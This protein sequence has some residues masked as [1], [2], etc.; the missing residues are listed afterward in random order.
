[1]NIRAHHRP[2]RQT[3]KSAERLRG[4]FAPA[5]GPVRAA[6]AA[7]AAGAHSTEES[8]LSR[9]A[10]N[11]RRPA[12]RPERRLSPPTN[13]M[14]I[15]C[16]FCAHRGRHPGPRAHRTSPVFDDIP[17]A[18]FVTPPLTTVRAPDHG[19]SAASRWMRWRRAIGRARQ[20]EAARPIRSEPNLSY[21]LSC[22]RRD[23]AFT[24]T[25]LGP[26][27]SR[28]PVTRGRNFMKKAVIATAKKK[29][30]GSGVCRRPWRRPPSYPRSSGH[31]RP[32]PP[33][34]GKAAG[35]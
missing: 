19:N 24:R 30:Y 7:G 8:G 13:V 34:R 26:F 16:L 5:L 17:I 12:A 4:A 3:T 11:W 31:R 6:R 33:W 25:R 32:M 10:A 28:R 15:G 23:E 1:M 22:R 2:R 21:A 18:R 35:Q 9:R 20:R 29:L 27:N 14:A